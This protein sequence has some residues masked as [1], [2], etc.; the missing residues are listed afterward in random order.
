MRHQRPLGNMVKPLVGAG[1]IVLDR[2]E[3]NVL[4]VF[5]NHS[6]KWGFPKGHSELGETI[7]RTAKRELHEETGLRCVLGSDTFRGIE[8]LYFYTNH[9]FGEINIQDSREIGF[10]RWITVDDLKT[11]HDSELQT[12]VRYWLKH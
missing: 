2:A 4:M 8:H 6:Q 10:V 5:N 11:L 9:V 12:D 7:R 3:R 1:C